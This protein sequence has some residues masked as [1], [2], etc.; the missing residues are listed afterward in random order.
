MDMPSM[1]NHLQILREELVPALGCTEPIAV[2]LAAAK[3]RRTLGAFPQSLTAFCSGNIVKNV[4]A[5]TVP[6]SGGLR[7]IEAAAV[8]GAVGGD[9]DAQLEVLA[10]VT[11]ADI[12][13]TRRLLEQEFCT[14]RLVD[15]VDKLYI[16]VLAE[17]GGH[18]AAVTIEGHHTHVSQVTLDG[19]CLY[20]D[21]TPAGGDVRRGDRSAL[22]IASIL[23][24]AGEAPL[25]QLRPILMR[26]VECNMAIAQAGLENPYGAGV[27]RALLD[28]PDP[29]VLTVARARAAAA[30]EARM[31]GCPLPVVINSGSGN[32]GITVS[33]PVAAYAAAKGV[34][35]ER[36]LRALAVSNLVSIHLKYYIGDLS[37]F[38]GAVTASCGVGAALA[39]LD[40][41]GYEAVA[42]TIT[43]TLA[44]V[45]GIFCDGAKPSCAAKISAA[46]DAA[47][48]SYHMAMGHR[49]FRPGEGV[50]GGD[51]EQTIRSV[52][53][54]GREGM[55]VAD[56]EILQVMMHPGAEMFP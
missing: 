39:W 19:R 4:K 43:N 53:L 56:K 22:T 23:E 10:A 28:E 34:G 44:A 47:F 25:D 52:G 38:C 51:V 29:S 12:Q 30:S 48:T 20:R 5:V 33:V 42:D 11:P 45:S 6:N 1:D 24:F 40:G 17:G 55:E 26:Q 31:S 36:M 7:G 35:E 9:A 37:A 41:G 13:T 15:G 16:C 46:L 3:A 14:T 49:A 21:Q 18:K 54:I 8:L 32:Q 50:V 2:A 27:A